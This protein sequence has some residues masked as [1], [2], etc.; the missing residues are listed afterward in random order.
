MLCLEIPHDSDIENLGCVC[1][2]VRRLITYF[3]VIFSLMVGILCKIPLM[4]FVKYLR[5][6]RYHWFEIRVDLVPT[7]NTCNFGFEIRVDLVP[8][9]NTCN[10]GLS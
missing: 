10:F 2:G 1:H 8:I 6:N 5:D 9:R 4:E 7:R 3:L